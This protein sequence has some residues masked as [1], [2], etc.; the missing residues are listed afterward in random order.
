VPDLVFRLR[1]KAKIEWIRLAFFLS[2]KATKVYRAFRKEEQ[3]GLDFTMLCIVRPVY[4][5]L[6]IDSINSLHLCNPAHKVKLHLD[7]AC[8][9]TFQTLQKNLD[10]P[11]KVCVVRVQEIANMPWQIRKMQVV[12]SAAKED[13]I[14]VDAD[15]YWRADPVPHIRRDRVLFLT[16][17]YGFGDIH[18]EK[19]LLE[20]V[21]R[22]PDWTAL[23]HYNITLVSIPSSLI[24]QTFVDVCTSLASQIYYHSSIPGMPD[25]DTQSL[26]RLCEEISLSVGAQEIIGRELI[27]TLYEQ[28]GPNGRLILESSYYGATHGVD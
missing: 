27:G 3:T 5:R 23:S 21:L 25:E 24:S 12:F 16:K 11:D 7:L 8:C 9:E 28:V 4:V 14:F 10:Y 20:E 1:R 15:T 2:R 22:H 17:N 6:A 13:S 26:R 18:R 19:L